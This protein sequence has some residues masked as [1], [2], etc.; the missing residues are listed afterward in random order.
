MRIRM[1]QQFNSIITDNII[2]VYIIIMLKQIKKLCTPAMVYFLISISTLLMMIFSNRN[3][4]STLCMGEYQCPVESLFFIYIVKLAYLFI[5]T[6]I[7]DSLCK[8]GYKSISWFLLLLPLLFYFVLLG[9]FMMTQNSK[10]VVEQEQK[11][12]FSPEPFN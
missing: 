2:F 11:K 12:S 10:V 8:N 1:L 4:V 7:L 3:S 5:V 6:I 9:L